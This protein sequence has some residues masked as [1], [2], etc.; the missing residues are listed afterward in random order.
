ML[1]KL[2][3]IFGLSAKAANTAKATST[4]TKPSIFVN[5]YTKV[6]CQGM[7]GKEVIFY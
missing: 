5:K 6:I 7:T 1:K 3:G 2:L 4:N